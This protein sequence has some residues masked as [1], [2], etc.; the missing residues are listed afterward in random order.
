MLQ[1][2]EYDLYLAERAESTWQLTLVKVV[3]NSPMM[4]ELLILTEFMVT[5]LTL[6]KMDDMRPFVSHCTKM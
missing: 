3:Y 6:I 2:M 5:A 4:L 1:Q